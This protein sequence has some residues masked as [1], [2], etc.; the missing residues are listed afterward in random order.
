MTFGLDSP[1]SWTLDAEVMSREGGLGGQGEENAQQAAGVRRGFALV[2]SSP[3]PA[4]CPLLQSQN[5]RFLPGRWPAPASLTSLLLS[6]A[7][8]LAS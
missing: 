7:L 8:V 5:F 4:W 3:E 2:F 1:L 6:R